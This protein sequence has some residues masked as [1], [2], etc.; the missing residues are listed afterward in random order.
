MNYFIQYSSHFADEETQS[1]RCC[2]RKTINPKRADSR[3]DQE[4]LSERAWLVPKWKKWKKQTPL[5][6]LSIN[7][8]HFHSQCLVPSPCY[9]YYVPLYLRPRPSS[10]S[11]PPPAL[12][13]LP[14]FYFSIVARRCCSLSLTLTLTLTLTHSWPWRVHM[15]A[16]GNRP[17]ERR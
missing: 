2:A 13:P 1:Q 3:T 6:S 10:T 9:H 7:K 14:M 17:Q 5:G 12:I 11:S 15:K 16:T 4:P 8:T